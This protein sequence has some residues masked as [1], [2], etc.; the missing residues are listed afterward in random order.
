M[1]NKNRYNAVTCPRMA[2]GRMTCK[3][4]FCGPAPMS[5]STALALLQANASWGEGISA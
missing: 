5:V 2:L 3:A 4:A 1:V